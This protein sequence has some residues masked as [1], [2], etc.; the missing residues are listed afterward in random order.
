VKKWAGEGGLNDGTLG[1][2]FGCRKA[3][4][5]ILLKKQSARQGRLE[6]NL[7]KKGGKKDMEGSVEKRANERLT[8]S[9]E[10]YG[11]ALLP[12]KI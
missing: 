3:R 10:L 4:I 5:A 8:S 6:P 2:K 9:G 1:K 7:E 12:R 11:Q